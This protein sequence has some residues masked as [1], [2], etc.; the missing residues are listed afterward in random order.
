MRISTRVPHLKK[1]TNAINVFVWFVYP[2]LPPVPIVP[3][4]SWFEW[5]A[6]VDRPSSATDQPIKRAG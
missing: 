2:R 1:T 6:E 5:R 3:S 4:L